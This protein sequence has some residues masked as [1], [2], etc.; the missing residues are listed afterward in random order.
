MNTEQ[1]LRDFMEEL[2]AISARHSV[3]IGGCGCC[4]SPW[5]T[6]EGPHTTWEYTYV[7]YKDGNGTL[8]SID[9]IKAVKT[10]V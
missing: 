1:R 2:K 5:L 3:Y 4:D 9:C 8:I 7:D 10:S 6:A